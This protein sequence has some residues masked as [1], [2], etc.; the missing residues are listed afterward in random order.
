MKATAST[1]VAALWASYLVTSHIA[2]AKK[3]FTI[4]KEL[5]FPAAKDI[6]REL[7]GEAAAKKLAQVLLSATTFT[8]LI[9]EIV[10]DV[11]AQLLERFNE[12]PWYAIQVDESTDVNNKA[13]LLVYVRYY[14]W[15][16]WGCV[17]SDVPAG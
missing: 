9:D 14:M 11:E 6:C 15:C 3:L 5:I 7:L 12:S 1:N 16:A 10:E 13:I 2:K 8:R 4:G 17:V